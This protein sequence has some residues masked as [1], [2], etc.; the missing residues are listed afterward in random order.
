[1]ARD[2]E[3]EPTTSSGGS[4]T[5]G[6]A[7][8]ARSDFVSMDREATELETTTGSSAKAKQSFEDSS[9]RTPS[10]HIGTTMADPLTRDE[11]NARL[12]AAEARTETRF[13][14]LTGTVDLKFTQTDHKVDRIAANVQEL[15]AVVHSAVTEMRADNKAT[16]AVV[17]AD[18]KST[19]IAVY[20]TI[21]AVLAL[22]A[23]L[24]I[25]GVGVENNMLAAFQA[26]I[27]VRT[28]PP[29]AQPHK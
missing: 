5:N 21:L 26:G 22:V 28:L 12:E 2:E 15:S 20:T 1:M 24:W 4:R 14:Q 23:A 3:D 7:E 19:R 27:G 10:A 11:M 16:I 13:A 6:H 8:S 18:G 17:K 25:A 9:D 29:D